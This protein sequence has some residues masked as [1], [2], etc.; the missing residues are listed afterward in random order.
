MK[1]LLAVLLCLIP[2]IATAQLSGQGAG[3]A[4][5]PFVIIEPA[6]P[7][8]APGYKA[9]AGRTLANYAAIGGSKRCN[10][11]WFGQSNSGANYASPGY[12]I[13][14][15]TLIFNFNIYNGGLYTTSA[16]LLGGGGPPSLVTGGS[17]AGGGNYLNAIADT[18]IAGGTCDRV[19]LIP[20]S[21]S[22]TTVA[23]WA[24]GSQAQRI[25]ATAARLSANGIPVSAICWTQGE[26]DNVA[27]TSQASYTASLAIVIATIQAQAA[28]SGV[29]IFVSR[30]SYYL[31]TTSANVVNA[32]IAAVNGTTVFALGNSDSLLA[33]DRRDDIHFD[34]SGITAW[35]AIAAPNLAANLIVY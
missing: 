7:T 31:G 32:Q 34:A 10:I 24:T 2:S 3:S 11:V 22:S 30:T 23:D 13:T 14:H 9:V 6:D 12:V 4:P 1:R 28:F 16:P 8:I 33:V 35:T 27:G 20:A 17:T 19:V 15:P 21:I 26:S 29:P 18:L 25:V 5:D